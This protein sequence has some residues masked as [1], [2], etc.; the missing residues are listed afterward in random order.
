MKQGRFHARFQHVS[1]TL[2]RDFISRKE[3]LQIHRGEKGY[4]LRKDII[5]SMNTATHAHGDKIHG[6]RRIGTNIDKN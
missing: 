5:A 1:R 3:D 4:R 2:S 6:V